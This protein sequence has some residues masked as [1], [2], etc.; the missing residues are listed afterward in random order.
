MASPSILCELGQAGEP[1]ASPYVTVFMCANCAR[2]SQTPEAVGRSRP[3]V[4]SFDWPMPVQEVLIP[5]T[6]RLQPEHVLKAFESGARLVAVVAC[7]EDNCHHLEG[8][9]RCARRVDY[10]RGILDEV[11]LGAE[12]LM[13]FSL[14]GTAAQDMARTAGR[15]EPVAGPEIAAG[16]ESAAAE[17]A[18]IRRAVLSALETLT[19]TPL[20]IPLTE[21]AQDPY[22]QV[23]ANYD[24]NED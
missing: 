8:S 9:K 4:P 19:P 14:P 10:V 7:R 20:D 5:C 13:L 16:P 6:G 1:G 15:Q 18:A 11:G 17:V 12:R 22:Q 21:A 23:D 3:S 2:A 24:D